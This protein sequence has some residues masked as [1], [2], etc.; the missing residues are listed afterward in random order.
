MRKIS[1]EIAEILE[2][3]SDDKKSSEVSDSISAKSGKSA[4]NPTARPP[5]I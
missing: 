4:Y 5:S 3:D 1:H 2:E